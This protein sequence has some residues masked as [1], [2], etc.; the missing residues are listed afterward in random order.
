MR[1]GIQMLGRTLGMLANRS[2]VGFQETSS[3]FGTPNQGV[4][5]PK[6]GLGYQDCLRVLTLISPMVHPHDDGDD[7]GC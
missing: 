5:P 7:D 6:Q 4:A 1:P 3:A 2:C